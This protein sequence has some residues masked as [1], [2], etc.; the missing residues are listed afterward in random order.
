VL[1]DGHAL[2]CESCGKTLEEAKAQQVNT[3]I[4]TLWTIPE[5][6]EHY[7]ISRS[8][9]HQ[10][11]KARNLGHKVGTQWLFTVEEVNAMKPGPQGRPRKGE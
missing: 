1:V 3:I 5:I 11:R 10:I 2:Y 7:D 8:R 9:T 4:G 6:A